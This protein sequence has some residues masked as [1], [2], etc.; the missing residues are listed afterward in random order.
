MKMIFALLIAGMLGGSALCQD[1]ETLADCDMASVLIADG[2]ANE[3]PMEWIVDSDEPKF[4]YN[5][6]SDNNNLYVRVRLKDEMARRKIALFGFTMWLD[7][8]GKKKRKI[9]LKFPTGEEGSERIEQFRQSA[10]KN[11]SPGERADFQREMN[12]YFIKDVEILELIGLSDD[13]L[14]STRSGITNGIKVG[15][16]VDEEEAYIYEAQVPF[17]SFRLS[18]ASIET[19]GIG[20]ETGKF[21]PKQSTNSNSTGGGGG[22]G[23]GWSGSGGG[24]GRRGGGGARSGSGA[25]GRSGGQPNGNSP[26]VNSTSYWVSVKVK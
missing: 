15:I 8:N 5:V 3:W 26:M 25:G 10:N 7:P 2:Q 1:K 19:L 6:C 20:F 18:K 13:P 9:G 16:G 24:G 17:K 4:S 23:G 21:V 14:T 12:R 22:G 11:M